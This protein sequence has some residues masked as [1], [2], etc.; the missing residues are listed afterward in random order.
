MK[1]V[2]ESSILLIS[3]N[4]FGLIDFCYCFSVYFCFGLYFFPLFWGRGSFDFNLIVFFYFLK[5]DAERIDLIRFLGLPMWL[6]A[7]LLS[8][9]STV[10]VAQPLAWEPPYAVCRRC[11]HLSNK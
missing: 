5:V 11:S 7:Q 9:A 3:K 6:T 2:K 4:H 10:A 8:V 1:L